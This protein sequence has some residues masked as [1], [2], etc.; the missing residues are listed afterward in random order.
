MKPNIHYM[1][2]KHIIYTA[3]APHL[4]RRAAAPGGEGGETRGRGEGGGRR[5]GCGEGA[6]PTLPPPSPPLHLPSPRGGRGRA[7]EERSGERPEDSPVPHGGSAC[8]W[9]RRRAGSTRQATS[10]T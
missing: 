9:S 8:R 2:I 5:P 6:S 7:D 3:S 1:D 10:A 4:R